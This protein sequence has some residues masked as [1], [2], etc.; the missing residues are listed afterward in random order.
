M[1]SFSDYLAVREPTLRHKGRDR[2]VPGEQS[3]PQGPLE[4]SEKLHIL[5]QAGATR[6]TSLPVAVG[7]ATGS[8]GS[9][10][11]RAALDDPA[12]VPLWLRPSLSSPTTHLEHKL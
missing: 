10:E 1:S 12:Q 6:E 7:E 9:Q 4:P 3:S 11:V 2:S 8:A 5:P